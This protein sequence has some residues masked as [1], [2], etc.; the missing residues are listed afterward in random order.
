MLWVLFRP[1]LT[2]EYTLP[3]RVLIMQPTVPKY[4][5]PVFKELAARSGLDV[6][7]CHGRQSSIP[8]TVPDGYKTLFKQYR[9]SGTLLGGF[10][11]HS[12]PIGLIS[13]RNFDVAILQ[14]NVRILSLPLTIL[15]C[16]LAG[17]PIVLWGHGYSKHEA[18][19]KA[20]MRQLM[21][22][23]GDAVLVYNRST[24]DALV[25]AGVPRAQTFVALN[26]VDPTPIR[27]EIDQ[28]KARPD[29]LAAFASK[30]WLPGGPNL[31]CVSRLLDANRIDRMITAV[32]GLKGRF[33]GIKAVL[34]GTGPAEAAL[35]A[36]A[37]KLKVADRVHFAGAIYEE[38]DLAPYFLT[39]H[40]FVYPENIGL[41][42]NHGMAYGLPIITSD[43]IDSQNPEIEALRHGHNGLLYAHGS[44]AAMQAAIARLGEDSTLRS[45]LSTGAYNTIHGRLTIQ[46]MVDG[47]E[48]S[49]RYALA[50]RREDP[51]MFATA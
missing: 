12:P 5:V 9:T 40:Q 51:S 34:V 35:R 13:K 14:W 26:A 15:R 47:M 42:L 50:I 6:T 33:A 20:T 10:E 43:R 27:Q 22:L 37:T 39:A 24:A 19:I 11:W 4:R 45:T 2:E 1:H 8:E 16:R 48:A 41:S 29:E 36:L 23:L 28:W 49:V 17:I 32:A 3:V 38:A 46:R 21:G 31:L 44:D 18:S 25:R 30:L 7:I